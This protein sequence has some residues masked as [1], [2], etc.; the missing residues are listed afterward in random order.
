[1]PAVRVAS[2]LPIVALAGWRRPVLFMSGAVIDGC[3]PRL[4]GA[5]S[6]HEIGHRRAFDNLKRLALAAC[7]DPL[8]R[9]ATGREITAAWEAAAEEAAD[10]AA[11]SLGAQP[12]DLAE[13]LLAVERLAP[14]G[15]RLVVPAAAFYQGGC[16]ERRVRRLLVEGRL[17]V[18]AQ[19]GRAR[20]LLTAVVF[21]ACWA[22]AAEALHRPARRLL[23]HSVVAH[24]GQLRALV[25]VRPR[26]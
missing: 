24:P 13:A 14:A 7:C 17:P 23:E 20:R 18:E 10:D 26:A 11:V 6:A 25:V 3:T 21:L 8:V 16:L 22:L 19:P 15:A 5:I 12:A 4:L 2:P 1:M 9:T